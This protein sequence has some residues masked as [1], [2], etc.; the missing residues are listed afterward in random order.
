VGGL[1]RYHVVSTRPPV[2]D[3]QAWSV[4]TKPYQPMLQ[5]GDA[6]E[7]EL[8]ANPVVTRK[9][10][11]K[12]A[13][14][15][16]VMDTK[17]QLLAERGLQTWA[18]VDP[19]DR[20]EPYELIAGACAH[21]LAEQGKRCGFAITADQLSVDGYRQ[22]TVKNGKLKFSTVDFMGTLVVTDAE[23]FVAMLHAGMGHAKAF[24]CGLMLVRRPL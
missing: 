2:Q 7:F 8:C 3:G 6:L 20:P 17:R 11:G 24:G 13:R 19:A 15:D 16:V 9:V 5:V 1:P 10:N 4:Q 12:H 21:W 23:K 14:H 18:S 22:H